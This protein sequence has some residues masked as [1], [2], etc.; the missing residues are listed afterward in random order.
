MHDLPQGSTVTLSWSIDPFPIFISPL[1][2]LKCDPYHIEVF[3]PNSI[4][5]IIIAFGPIKAAFFKL[6]FLF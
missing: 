6:G 2:P 4:L 5:P 3:S 1:S